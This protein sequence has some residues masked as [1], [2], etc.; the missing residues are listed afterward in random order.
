MK[1]DSYHE[2]KQ[3]LHIFS[4]ENK[5]MKLIDHKR[6]WWILHHIS[7]TNVTLKYNLNTKCKKVNISKFR[8]VTCFVQMATKV[9]SGPATAC[10]FTVGTVKTE[11]INS[12]FLPLHF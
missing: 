9:S 5:T 10:K 3:N 2:G 4:Q 1:D 6:L 12:L 7:T 8:E 11:R